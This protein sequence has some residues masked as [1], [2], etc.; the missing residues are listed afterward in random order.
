MSHISITSKSSLFAVATAVIATGCVTS[1][2]LA[3]AAPPYPLAPAC[4][5]Y[6]FNGEF[7]IR[8]ANGW[9][10]SF[11]S[12]GSAA[13]GTAVVNFDDGGQVTGI[14]SRGGIQGRS[15][16]FA[17]L[18]NDKPD[19][20]WVFTGT[21]SDDG[22]VHNGNEY[23]QVVGPR[24]S[25]WESLRPLACIDLDTKINPLPGDVIVAPEPKA[26]PPGQAPK[27]TATVVGEDVDVYNVKNEPD[28]AGQVIGLLRVGTQVE[29]VGGCAPSSWCQVSG[30]NVPTG[31]GWVWG[32][33]QF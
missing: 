14:V 18:W 32:H 10:V 19:N 21:V 4:A 24:Q 6:G 26:P 9:N 22:L 16:D 27:Q 28:G 31:N 3:S 2:T 11:R 7:P 1:P 30:A 12:N 25:S 15:V 13:S 5:N 20:Q 29:L 8:G 17:I 33:L 23:P